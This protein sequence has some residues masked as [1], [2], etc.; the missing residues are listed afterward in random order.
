MSDNICGLCI[1]GER[2]NKHQEG[3]KLL[4][5]N[6]DRPLLPQCGNPATPSQYIWSLFATKCSQV[7]RMS[8]QLTGLVWQDH[9]GQS[10]LINGGGRS[11]LQA[12]IQ[13]TLRGGDHIPALLDP[14]IY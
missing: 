13:L 3:S 7:K 14:I 2:S 8:T 6:T 5:C 4:P 12:A 9:T 10:H 11:Q 1:Y